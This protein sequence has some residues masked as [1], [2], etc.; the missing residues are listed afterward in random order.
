MKHNGFYNLALARHIF[1][2]SDYVVISWLQQCWSKY[3]CQIS[4]IH[5]RAF[6]QYISAT[7]QV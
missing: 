5:L 4:H 6:Q 3:Y 1:N 2:H 7:V